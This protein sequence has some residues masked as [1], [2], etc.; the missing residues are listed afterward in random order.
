MSCEDAVSGNDQRY[1]YSS[2]IWK[3]ENCSS[4]TIYERLWEYRNDPRPVMKLNK[5]YIENAANSNFRAEYE[6]AKK[7]AF[8]SEWA[9]KTAILASN[10]PI[11]ERALHENRHQ[12]SSVSVGQLYENSLCQGITQWPSTHCS[13]H[14][15]K[16]EYKSHR[17]RLQ[18]GFSRSFSLALFNGLQVKIAIPSGASWK[19]WRGV[20]NAR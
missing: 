9:K 15:R 19:V 16:R 13:Y 5:R 11:L 4:N 14:V 7:T 10:S 12:L 8:S 2:T 17:Q 18:L 20:L 1:P 3:R 6:W